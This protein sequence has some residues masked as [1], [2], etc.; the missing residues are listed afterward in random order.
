MECCNPAGSGKDRAALNMIHS[1][2][3]RDKLPR[4]IYENRCYLNQA[5]LNHFLDFVAS[6]PHDT[7]IKKVIVDAV[8]HTKIG[9]VLV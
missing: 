8:C 6:S 7:T 3:A 5:Y 2:E 9:Y 1:A 4:P